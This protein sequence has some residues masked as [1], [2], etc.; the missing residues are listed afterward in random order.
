MKQNAIFII[1]KELSLK[2]IKI[3]LSEGESSTSN[4]KFLGKCV[5]ASS[6]NGWMNTPITLEWVPTVLRF[7]S[8]DHQLLG[9]DS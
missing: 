2:L 7:F 9:W 3:N 5:I 1:F 6:E 8:F 4:Q